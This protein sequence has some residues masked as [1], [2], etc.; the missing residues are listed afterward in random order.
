MKRAIILIGSILL[1]AGCGPFRVRDIT[2]G[3]EYI[4]NGFDYS[5]RIQFTDLKSGKWVVLSSCE[6]ERITPDV[7]NKEIATQK[8]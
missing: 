7:A 1:L 8:N 5:P 6:I 4:T 2:T 3:K